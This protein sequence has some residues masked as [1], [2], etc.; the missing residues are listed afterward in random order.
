MPRSETPHRPV[1]AIV[2]GEFARRSDYTNWRP[3][4]SGDWLM[5][6]TRSGAGNIMLNGKGRRLGAGEAV[7]Y[8][9]LAAQ[10]YSTDQTVGRWHLLW[11]HFRP[12]PLWR[13]WLRWPEVAAGV[14]RV[15]LPEGD[16]RNAFEA[17]LQRTVTVL[18]RPDPLSTELGLNALEEALLRAQQAA[19]RRGAAPLDE[20]V[21]RALNFLADH[22]HEPFRLDALAAH[23]GLSS[24]R[25]SHLFKE[26]TGETPQRYAEELKMRAAQQ[27]LAHTSL[28]VAEVAA[29]TGFEDPFYFAK[30]FRRFARCTPTEYRAKGAA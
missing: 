19:R 23:C 22:S 16:A 7:L 5:I 18:K 4:G 24:S 2:A 17:A 29:E 1:E 26:R 9:P 28:T 15:V 12:R 30:R 8:S 3:R 13:A 6:Y 10:D 11:A 14:G 20:R 21:Q 25:L 27:L